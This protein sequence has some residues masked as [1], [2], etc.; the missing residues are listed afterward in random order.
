MHNDALG[1]PQA[2]TDESG[3]TVWT[4][5]Y[6][7]FGKATV[8]EDP[9]ND[10]N[11]VTLNVRMPG[12]YEDVETGLYYNG[13]RYYS[14]ET[15]RY[16]TADPIGL[17]G[18][19]NSYA[20]VGNDP[21]RWIDSNGLRGRSPFGTLTEIAKLLLENVL[22]E[23]GPSWLDQQEALR[24]E[25]FDRLSDELRK[26]HALFDP[27]NQDGFQRRRVD[28]E[29]NCIR[30]FR[31]LCKNSGD[32]KQC[33]DDCWNDYYRQLHYYQERNRQIERSLRDLR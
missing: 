27:N 29:L 23:N 13:Y 12:Q 4:A 15:G 11:L 32:Q 26:N 16:L 9:D 17:A 18:G 22:T 14:P 1:T 8:N 20:Y 21:L 33:R 7:P 30:K 10:G 19:L 25:E 5:E 24:Q 2:L 6:D 28:C 31:G 3:T